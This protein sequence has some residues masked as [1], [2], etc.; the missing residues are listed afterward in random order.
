MRGARVRWYARGPRT[1][2]D[3]MS[4]IRQLPLG[5]RWRDSSTFATFVQGGN[6][7]VLEQLRALRGGPPVAL[8]LWGAPAS[9]RT[10]LLQASCAYAG[11]LG[12]TAAYLSPAGRDAPGPEALDGCESLDLVCIDDVETLSG[13]A[14]WERALFNLYNGLQESGGHLLL[15]ATQPPAGVRWALADLQ[16]RMGGALTLQVKGLAE[17]DKV[18]V[19]RLRA[20]NR[21]L[22]LPEE[23]AAFLLRHFPRD[24]RSLCRLLDTLDSASLAAQRRLT[25]PFIKEAIEAARQ[26]QPAG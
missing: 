14:G 21:G 24:L 16:S 25:V 11:E 17:A 1:T 23:T 20:R 12:R 9:G 8:W 3:V 18:Q 7:L 4:E 19:L 2:P 6:A 10:H 15:A 5:V 26:Q 22:E 13:Q